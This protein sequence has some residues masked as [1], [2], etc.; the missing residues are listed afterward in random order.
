V[1]DRS[2]LRSLAFVCVTLALH[3]CALAGVI[4]F[5][6][7]FGGFAQPLLHSW[8]AVALWLMV[9]FLLSFSCSV[10]NHNH[11]HAP[12]FRAAPLNFAYRLLLTLT[13][14][15]TSTTVIVTH[16]MNHHVHSGTSRDWIDPALVAGKMGIARVALY[17]W[18]ASASLNRNRRLPS[19][20]QLP[21]HMARSERVEKIVLYVAIVAGL[22]WNWR[23]FLLFIALPWVT[24]MLALVAVNLLQH[25]DAD[26]ENPYAQSR[27]FTGALTNWLL[28][29]N[30]YHTVHHLK[31][32]LHWS[33]AP[34][35]HARIAAQIPAALNERSILWYAARRYVFNALSTSDPVA[36]PRRT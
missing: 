25:D 17:V 19:A 5:S 21:A 1:R 22:V 14:G 23:A 24:S 3:V 32:S 13:K 18:R 36:P 20:P 12:T 34:A 30:G 16:N 15:Y 2:D 31:P 29:N 9:S 26:P 33:K 8:W 28:F 10:I 27:N 11:V 7:A 4:A 35:E 6:P